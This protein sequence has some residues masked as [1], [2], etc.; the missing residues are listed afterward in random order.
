MKLNQILDFKVYPKLT[1]TLWIFLF[2]LFLHLGCTSTPD[3]NELSQE[4]R[5]RISV[6]Y[7]K[8]GKEK[9]DEIMSNPNHKAEDFDKVIQL[10]NEGLRYLPQNTKIRK[11]LVILYF[12][13]GKGYVK[14]KGLYQAM[15][16]AAKEKKDMVKAQ[17]YQKLA[18][19]SEKKALQSYQQVIF[20]LNILLTQRKPY[21]PQEEMAFL[22]YLLVS[23]VYL[24]QYEE[25]IKLIDG[26]I[27]SLPDDDPR[28]E[29]LMDMK[30]TIIEALQKARQE[31][32]E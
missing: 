21:D 7:M 9:F 11:D 5:T 22:N 24:K 19:E 28:I 14:R 3:P 25:A 18:N 32:M 16:A 31:K 8:K 2:L 4:E 6:S 1:Y 27:Q 26:E 12:N 20:H 13:L 29:R 10:W 30:E 17:E 15:A 23:H